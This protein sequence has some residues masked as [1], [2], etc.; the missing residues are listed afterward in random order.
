[1]LSPTCLSSAR[2]LIYIM[3]WAISYTIFFNQPKTIL[4]PSPKIAN[5][6]LRCPLSLSLSISF[7][8]KIVSLN[9][10]PQFSQN[11]TPLNPSPPASNQTVPPPDLTLD[12]ASLHHSDTF[13]A[14]SHTTHL[15]SPQSPD[16]IALYLSMLCRCRT[17]SLSVSS[18]PYS[19]CLS[20]CLDY[21]CLPPTIPLYVAK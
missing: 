3:L 16:Q 17:H 11:V 5:L 6:I 1:M 13:I 2:Q 8:F 9:I 4:I 18:L 20:D 7:F 12:P 14:E 10:S 19:S 21:Y 15:H